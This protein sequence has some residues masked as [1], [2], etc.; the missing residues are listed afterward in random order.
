MK[1]YNT[2][3]YMSTQDSNDIV[4]IPQ[5][6]ERYYAIHDGQIHG[7]EDYVASGFL[8]DAGFPE[9]KEIQKKKFEIEELFPDWQSIPRASVSAHC[10][11]I[12]Y[13][14]YGEF[15]QISLFHSEDEGDAEWHLNIITNKINSDVI[16]IYSYN[17]TK[18]N[19]E[20]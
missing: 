2:K 17:A 8:D 15:L 3:K 1:K 13:G 18:L 6:F 20:K 7:F 10:L 11:E 4:T 9:Y 19:E 16:D 5:I 14:K 12:E